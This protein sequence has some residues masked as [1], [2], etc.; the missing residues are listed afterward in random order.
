MPVHKQSF[1]KPFL[2]L[3]TYCFAISFSPIYAAGKTGVRIDFEAI[4]A[5]SHGAVY[6]KGFSFS[7]NQR[8]DI[9]IRTDKTHALQVRLN[10]TLVLTKTDS[11]NFSL[12]RFDFRQQWKNKNG[13]VQIKGYQANGKILIS[14]INYNNNNQA[15]RSKKLG[16]SNLYR[17]EFI[18]KG[19]VQLDN[20]LLGRNGGGTGHSGGKIKTPPLGSYYHGTY[21][22]GISGAEDDILPKDVASYENTSGKRAAW[23]YF[24]NNWY[25]SRAFPRKT[26][27]WISKRGSV[28]FIRIMTRTASSNPTPNDCDRNTAAKAKCR[29]SVDAINLGLLDAD[30]KAWGQGAKAFGKPLIVEWGTEMNGTWFAW[31]AKHHG[32][33]TG[34]AKFRKAF[35]RIHRIIEKEAG[36]KNITWVFHVNWNDY[37]VANWNRL[38]A[39]YPGDDVID[40]LGVSI[41]SAQAP[42]DGYWTDF[43]EAM[44]EVYPRLTSNKFGKNKPI[45]L[46]EFGAVTI[47]DE[48]GTRRKQE[49][50][51]QSALD[52]IFS[53]RWPR[54]R[55]FSWWNERW[56]NDNNP[57]HNTNMRV[58]NNP[59]L[60]KV[61]RKTLQRES[62]RVI[63]RPIR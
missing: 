1:L 55:G 31:N 6:S 45:M 51:A 22:G 32:V 16:W 40:W 50:F 41:Y 44:D 14:R 53:N 60:A 39:Y 21:P 30:L 29:F 63:T 9:V 42:T 36:A 5:G 57:A 18:Q 3:I 33:T 38:E 10:D 56:E 35:R 8:R 47:T 26:A 13:S 37:P 27:T 49:D 19:S 43:T 46:L 15:F 24:S 20:F 52:S 58:Q 54:L 48:T 12:N 61:I 2:A 25:Q 28:P 23:V 62:R 11:G 4:P 59:K 17:V 34:A 7:P